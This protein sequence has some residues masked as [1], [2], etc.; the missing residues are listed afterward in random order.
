MFKPV[1]VVAAIVF[2]G[3]IGEPNDALLATSQKFIKSP[4]FAGL[5]FVGAF[6]LKNDVGS[7]NV[8]S[9]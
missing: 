5:V 2:L 3:S 8:C 6:V 7:I 9:S 1:R 4:D